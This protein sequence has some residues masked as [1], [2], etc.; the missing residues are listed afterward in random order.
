MATQPRMDADKPE[1]SPEE[2]ERLISEKAY[3]RALSRGSGGGNPLD[4]WLHAEKEI[5]AK[6]EVSP[7]DSKLE[8][9]YEQLAEA[10]EKLR[11]LGTRMR[12]ET[13]EEWAEEVEQLQ[14]L[15][16]GFG[17]R[18]NEVREVTGEAKERAKRQADKLW[19]ELV[20]AMKRMGAQPE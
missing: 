2:R 8:L 16:D 5:D 12:S 7:H 14:K 3:F 10:N 17:Q 6:F 1:I 11:E 15:R 13:R 9:L 18:L 19:K 4:D 20:E